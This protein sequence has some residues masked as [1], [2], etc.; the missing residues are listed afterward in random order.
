MQKLIFVVRHAKSSWESPL[1]DLD[2][3]LNDRG[4]RTAPIMAAL[5]KDLILGPTLVISS[6][7][8]RAFSTAKV[9]HAECQLEEPIKVVND[10]Y[11]GDEESYLESIRK[12]ADKF[13][14]VAL[15]G[16]NPKVE[17]F[18]ARVVNGYTGNVPTCA[19]MSFI[20]EVNEW[21]EVDWSTIQYNKHYF[22]KELE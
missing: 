2:R 10:L 13:R 17:D 11:F 5:F 19:I 20:S 4:I 6:P 15:F 21:K 9:F 18:S 1:K 14:T 8:N 12:V 16:H 22:P 7:A 3:P